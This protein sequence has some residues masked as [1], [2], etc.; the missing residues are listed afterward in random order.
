MNDCIGCGVCNTVCKVIRMKFDNDGFLYAY[1]SLNECVNCNKCVYICPNMLKNNNVFNKKSYVGYSKN[2]EFLLKSSSGAIF[3]ELA[4]NFEIVYGAA[5]DKNLKLKHIR[6]NNI[7]D[8]SKL[9]SSKYIQSDIS[10]IWDNIRK[11]LNNNEK[12]LFSGTPCQIAALKS[13]IK[14][15]NLNDD[16][17]YCVEIIC[18]GVPS[19]KLLD[20]Y[21]DKFKKNIKRINFRYKEKSWKKYSIKIDLENSNFIQLAKNNLYMKKYLSNKNLRECCYNCKFKIINSFADITIGDAWGIKKNFKSY[22][23]MGTS[24]IIINSKKGNLLFNNIKSNLYTWSISLDF[25]KKN[26]PC[27]YKSIDKVN[28]F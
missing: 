22:N 27:I 7:H 21:L 11:D 5:F 17:L 12:I 3:P 19:Q 20:N 15:Y 10:Q 9:Y 26:N 16:R 18:H 25:I 14:Y 2:K 24:Y 13:F 23:K 4:Q 28:T 8:L 6:V 1:T